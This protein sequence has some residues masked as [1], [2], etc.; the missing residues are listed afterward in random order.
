MDRVSLPNQFADVFFDAVRQA[1]LKWDLEPEVQV[2]WQKVPGG[3][4]RY[5]RTE[6]VSERFEMKFTFDA[7]G[8]VR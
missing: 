2:Y 7:A 6:A 3:E 1:V 8:S 5:L 4:D